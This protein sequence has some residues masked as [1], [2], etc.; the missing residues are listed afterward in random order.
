MLPFKFCWTVPINLTLGV[1]YSTYELPNRTK[2][3]FCIVSMEVCNTRD[4]LGYT[5]QCAHVKVNKLS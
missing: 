5:V 1:V 4:S 3:K 2:V